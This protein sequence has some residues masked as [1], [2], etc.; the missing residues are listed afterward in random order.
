[1]ILYKMNHNNNISWW[2]I[3]QDGSSYHIT[4]G[5]DIRTMSVPTSYHN[6]YTAISPERAAAE[7]ESRINEQR[8]RR[9][10]T[11]DKPKSVPDRPMLAQ[12]W[13]EHVKLI[14]NRKREPFPA[15]AVQPK[16]DGERCIANSDR[17]VSRRNVEIV[18]CPHIQSLLSCLPPEIKLDG[19]LY[20]PRTDLQTI[21]SYVNRLRPHK[22]Y[23]TIEYHVFDVID[24]EMPFNER[25]N[26]FQSTVQQ[27][28]EAH[29]EIVDAQREIPEKSRTKTRIIE[30]CPI[31][32]VP[33]YLINNTCVSEQARHLIKQHF[34]AFIK[35]GYEGAIVR[36]AHGMYELDY[37]SP[38]LL[39]YKE[40]MDDEFVIIDVS[41]GHDATGIF[42]CKTEDGNIFEATPAWTKER[43]KYLLKN[44]EKYIGK[45]LTVE[46]EKL[47]REGTPLK[48]SGKCTRDPYPEPL[49]EPE[50]FPELRIATS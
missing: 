16:I 38:D 46:Y 45:Y 13:P 12:K 33:T 35:E 6:A 49:P 44:K 39:K 30:S 34:R 27:L 7:M 18:S 37:R 25:L 20:I 48:P 17:M 40:V 14:D 2:K 41:E 15:V 22:L 4:W 3:E 23:Y 50:G 9:G 43:K 42:V 31:K 47:S 28:T 11:E 19:E 10:Y 26:V 5:H 21:Q 32:F 24:L 36:N 29:R 8:D 1:M